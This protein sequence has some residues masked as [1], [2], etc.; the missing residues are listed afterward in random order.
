M[1]IWPVIVSLAFVTGVSA[2]TTLTDCQVDSGSHF[3]LP[4]A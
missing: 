2:Q 3:V 4:R 1:K